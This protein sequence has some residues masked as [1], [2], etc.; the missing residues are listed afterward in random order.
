MKFTFT[1]TLNDESRCY[2]KRATKNTFL[3]EGELTALHV[4]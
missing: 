1:N 3:G 4:I 2:M